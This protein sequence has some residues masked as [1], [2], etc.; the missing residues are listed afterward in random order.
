MLVPLLMLSLV[1]IE[2]LC[3]RRSPQE[4]HL[5]REYFSSQRR[6]SPGRSLDGL[7]GTRRKRHHCEHSLNF[8]AADMAPV[9]W[10]RATK[11]EVFSAP[12]TMRGEATSF[13]SA[14]K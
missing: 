7:T 8:V 6:P 10:D 11:A 2:D 1:V 5:I 12:E 4:S 14:S 3:A 13:V 9:L